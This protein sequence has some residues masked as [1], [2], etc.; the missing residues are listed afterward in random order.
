MFEWG[1]EPS[2]I[3]TRALFAGNE[4]PFPKAPSGTRW[5]C[6]GDALAQK[7][8]CPTQVHARG[9]SGTKTEVS[10]GSGPESGRQRRPRNQLSKKAPDHGIPCFE[11][12]HP[13][14]LLPWD[15]SVFVPESSPHAALRGATQPSRPAFPACTCRRRRGYD[16]FGPFVPFDS[17]SRSLRGRVSS[18]DPT[19]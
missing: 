16:S 1:H 19:R 5:R 10:H 18:V 7:P 8:S 17:A 12:L 2:P 11:G 15:D 14:P 6:Y 13:F 3:E 9:D 4:F